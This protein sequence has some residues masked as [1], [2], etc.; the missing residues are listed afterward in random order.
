MQARKYVE[1]WAEHLLD[2][3]G[4]EGDSDTLQALLAQLYGKSQ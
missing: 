2:F 1:Q 3:T 4:Q